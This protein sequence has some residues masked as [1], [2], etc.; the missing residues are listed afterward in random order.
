MIVNKAEK[1]GKVSMYLKNKIQNQ[2][3][4][5]LPLPGKTGFDWFV[6]CAFL[7]EFQTCME[8]GVGDGG[9]AYSMLQYATRTVLVDN[10]KQGWKKSA[11]EKFL[12]SAESVDLDSKDLVKDY[13]TRLI[14]LDAAKDYQGTARDLEYC[15]SVSAEIIIVDDF[16]QSF[17][18]SV[19]MA[20]FDFIKNTD[21]RIAFVGNHQA[22]LARNKKISDVEKSLLSVLPIIMVDNIPSLTYGKLPDIELLN[23]LTETAKLQYTW[24]RKDSYDKFH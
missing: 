1:N 5:D 20:T 11:C 3:A 17:W 18:P 7:N 8:I 4:G 13:N 2:I 10:W 16:L 12:Q 24:A 22:V 21:W 9:S 14:H 15:N 19:S 6:Y 23:T